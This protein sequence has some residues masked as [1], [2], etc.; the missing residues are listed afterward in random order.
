MRLS[1][2]AELA[3]RGVV[4]LAEHYGDGPTTLNNICEA[5]DLPKQYL[6]KLFSVLAKADIITAVRGKK[7]GYV[8]SRDP[9]R[10]SV[11]QVVEAIEGPIA[12]NY[13]QHV[14][15]KCDQEGCAIRPMWHELQ[16]IVRQKLG[17]M[18]IGVA[19]DGSHKRGS[20]GGGSARACC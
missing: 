17:K 3:I 1:P 7:G 10:I 11:L 5:R 19:S 8:L 18:T 2:A 9:K 20:H 15:P 16:G 13:C 14:P 6:V 4:V 12:L